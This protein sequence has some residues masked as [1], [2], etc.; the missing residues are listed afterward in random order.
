MERRPATNR[1]KAATAASW[2][3]AARRSL[4]SLVFDQAVDESAGAI[5]LID[6]NMG[7]GVAPRRA[8]LGGPAIPSVNCGIFLA[9]PG[10]TQF[11]S[12]FATQ[13]QGC[14]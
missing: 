7:F 3:A 6:G 1:L 4:G 11:Q 9:A 10:L 8:V 2:R 12:S 13:Q 5:D 14:F